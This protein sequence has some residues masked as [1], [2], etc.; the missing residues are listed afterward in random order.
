MSLPSA[1]LCEMAQQLGEL[2]PGSDSLDAV[3]G[4]LLKRGADLLADCRVSRHMMSKLM[5]RCRDL[6]LLL[7]LLLLRRKLVGLAELLAKNLL[8]A[9]AAQAEAAELWIRSLQSSIATHRRSTCPEEGGRQSL[10][11][12][13]GIVSVR[14]HILHWPSSD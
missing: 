13:R 3:L 12:K 4:K 9:E 1:L 8:T 5:Q 11:E 2:L 10:S 7:R 14:H 6:L